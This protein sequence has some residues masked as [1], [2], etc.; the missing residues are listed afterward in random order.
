M[1]EKGG[2]GKN[3][4]CARRDD[5]RD[6]RADRGIGR[7]APPGGS[8]VGQSPGVNYDPLIAARAVVF[9]TASAK[10]GRTH[11][12]TRRAIDLS[13]VGRSPHHP[14]RALIRL[15]RWAA[16]RNPRLCATSAPG[17][18]ID[19]LWSWS[20]RPLSFRRPSFAPESPAKYFSSSLLVFGDTDASQTANSAGGRRRFDD[21]RRP[22]TDRSTRR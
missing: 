12:H 5:V 20:T 22:P 18:A 10:H 4:V 6:A 19:M 15:F 7:T 3:S 8:G 14:G 13:W 21:R 17:Q 2:A 9:H 16:E 1:D 11:T